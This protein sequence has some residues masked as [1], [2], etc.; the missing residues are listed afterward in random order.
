[1]ILRR[2][3]VFVVAV[4][5][6]VA[7]AVWLAEHPG[8]VTVHWQGWRVDTSVAIL[9]LALL[10]VLGL[11]SVVAGLLRA[12]V[13]APARWLAGRRQRRRQRG[14]E[15][16]ADGLA[17][18]AV[19]DRRG[20]GRL[21]RRADR[22]LADPALTGLLS[23]Q[24]AE[25]S[26]D[27]VEI[28][29]R[30]TAL[31]ERPQ[32]APVGLNGLLVLAERR[33]DHAGA[34]D[35]ARRAWAL[36]SAAG[37]LANTLFDLQMRAGQWSEAEATLAEARRRGALTGEDVRHRQSLVLLERSVLAEREGDPALALDLARRAHGAD[38]TLV[39]AAVRAARLLQRA[40]KPRRAAATLAATWRLAPHPDLV[41]ATIAL[42]PAETPLQRVKRLQKLVKANPAAASG[43]QALAEAALA[44]RLWG[45]ARTHLEQ[46]AAEAPPS[47]AVY[48]LLARL[49]REE[50][51][52]EAAAQLWLA[53]AP[54]V[55]A[56]A[57]WRCAACGATAE[58]WSSLC[59]ACGAVDRLE[60]RQS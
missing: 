8:Q 47:G 44:A 36:G 18:V 29:R 28:E 45:L 4:A 53:K 22:L 51:H 37:D 32:T 33:G 12:V 31:V 43:H 2:L 1:M 55:D 23:A 10:A 13:A 15:A 56:E 54:Q 24:A 42:G 58:R 34:L 5:L 25:L 16:L 35:F 39:A 60:W 48:A 57:A 11:F 17:A 52:D 27:A 38:A 7:A 20:A 59:P 14:Y 49:E 6:L 19:G 26:G 30:L 50:R 41:E 46:V 9:V 21:A 40:G 3:F